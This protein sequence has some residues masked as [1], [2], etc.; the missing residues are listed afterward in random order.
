[1]TPFSLGC[2][3]LDCTYIGVRA[4]QHL[5]FE[6]SFRPEGAPP[7]DDLLSWGSLDYNEHFTIFDPLEPLLELSHLE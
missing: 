7:S 3:R 5:R 2:L 4:T 6:I 1:M